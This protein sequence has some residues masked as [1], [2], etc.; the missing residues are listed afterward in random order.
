MKRT[1]IIRTLCLLAALLISCTACG[2]SKAPMDSMA[3]DDRYYSNSADFD[4]NLKTESESF[5]T[6]SPAI[7]DG[8]M[9][10]PV[11]PEE[12]TAGT[13]DP[14]SQ[15]KIV[16]TMRISAETKAFDRATA[17]IEA[18]CAQLGG[19]IESS[20]R[21]GGSIRY[22]SAVV[23]RSAAY[24]LRI[25]AEQ[26]DAFRAG[27]DGEINVVSENT[28]ISDITDRYFDVDTR[29][30]TLK[31][32]EERLL[33]MLE[34]ATE[35][36]YLITLESR[37]S[38]VRYQIESYTGTLRRYDSQVAY[39]TVHLN[40]DEVLEYTQVI[41]APQTFGERMSIALQESWADFVDNCKD[42]AVGFVYA[43]PTLIVLAVIFTAAVV[44]I[45]SVVKKH[46]RKPQDKE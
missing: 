21:S 9:N 12:S 32:E 5:V 7:S 34:K 24:T 11:K 13:A 4:Y 14:L 44:I 1:R 35:L 2:A 20:S 46:R 31:T 38:E 33:A 43:L 27:M 26:L 22:S 16:K 45:V 28:G 41:E 19:Y 8:A 10:A 30:A 39:S 17:A 40:L 6:S 15:R 29:L 3:G 36:E 37:L 25:P 23:A 18:L 42:F